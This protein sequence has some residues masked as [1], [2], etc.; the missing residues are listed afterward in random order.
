MKL[1]VQLLE[2]S[3]RA[4]ILCHYDPDGAAAA[5][6]IAKTLI[7]GGK[8][9]H[10]T[11]SSVLD[12]EL[13]S[14]FKEEGNDLTIVADMGSGQLDMLERLEGGTIVLDHHKPHG[15]SEKVVHVNPHLAGIDGVR[16]VC[17]ASM[18]WI[19]SM[20]VDEANWDLAGIA[21]AGAIGDRQ[22]VDGFIGLN[23]E[24][25]KEAEARK[26][27]VKERMLSLR[28]MPLADALSRS[29][30]PYIVGLTGRRE[31]CVDFIN[32]LGLD[33]EVSPRKLPAK[34]RRTLT[35]ML[36]IRM[37]KQGAQPEAIRTLVEEKYWI[38]ERGIYAEEMSALINSCSRLGREGLGVS[39]AIG[40]GGALRE[41]EVLRDDYFRQ[42]I[43]YLHELEKGMFTKKRIQFFYCP[44]PTLAGAVAGIGMQYYFNGEMPSVGFSV[45]EKATKVSSR[46]NRQLVARG[47]DLSSAMNEAAAEVGGQGGG[48][49][50]A[51][52]A[53]IPKGKEEKFISLVDDIVDRQLKVKAGA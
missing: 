53:T 50:I 14:K 52:G 21:M 5:A 7:R 16:E 47:L 10:I 4:R 17:G 45:L 3:R 18:A 35:S 13:L 11:L 23:S 19:F 12:E 33:S 31:A 8:E 6:T 38:P 32:S 40:D 41:A 1:G 37:M 34:E 36:A 51:A 20:V 2:R 30:S 26:V 25:F 46:G 27:L 15:D 39:L 9:F 28:D 29:L 43:G 24:L 42:I 44:E 48:H 22:H 49:N